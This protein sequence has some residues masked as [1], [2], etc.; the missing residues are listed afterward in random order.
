MR[1]RRVTRPRRLEAR[2]MTGTTRR[3]AACRA[4]AVTC[5]AADRPTPRCRCR[6]RS[7]RRHSRRRPGAVLAGEA[8]VGHDDPRDME[9]VA[10]CVTISWSRLS[11]SGSVA[12]VRWARDALARNLDGVS[13]AAAAAQRTGGA[14]RHERCGRSSSTPPR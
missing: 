11:A 9:A 2:S 10:E 8:I 4:A 5:A 3:P 7:S 12:I 13:H 1:L 14:H 6:W